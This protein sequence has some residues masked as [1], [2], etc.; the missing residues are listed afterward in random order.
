MN[1]VR[2]IYV[3]RMTDECDMEDI[4]EI[5]KISRK[6]NVAAEITGMLCYDPLYFLQCLEGPKA[7]VNELYNHIVQDDRHTDVLL[8]EYADVTE[9]TF[10]NWSMGFLRGAELDPEIV[11]RY[12]NNG[13]FNPYL[14]TGEEARNFL[15]TVAAQERDRLDS[16]VE[17]AKMHV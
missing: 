4:Q 9:R 13:R 8:L 5:L 16:Q 1:M 11:T 14:L 6:N 12:S 2:L 3:S 7:K 15:V 17:A 10:G